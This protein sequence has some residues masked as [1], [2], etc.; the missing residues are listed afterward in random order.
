MKKYFTFLILILVL[1]ITRINRVNAESFYEDNYISG[2]YANLI[3]GDFSKPQQMRFIRRK[4]DN[5]PSYCITPRVLLYDTED[6]TRYYTF[7]QDVLNFS[8]SKLDKV[9]QI[10]YFGYGYPGHTEDYWYAITQVM[11]WKEIEPNMDIFF[12][13]TKNGNRILRFENEMNEINSLI[14]EWNEAPA[15]YGG[16]LTTNNEY[17]YTDRFNV[18]HNYE[19]VHDSNID[20]TIDNDI[21]KIKTYDTGMFRTMF[22]KNSNLY[23]DNPYVYTASKGQDIFVQGSIG[24]KSY[25]VFFNVTNNKLQITKQDSETLE[26]LKGAIYNLY[27]DKNEY[28][29]KLTTDSNGIG[30][31]EHLTTGNYKLK[32]E[33]APEGYLVD[34]NTYN[35]TINEELTTLNLKDNIIKANLIINKT[36]NNDND[37]KYEEGIKFNIYDLNDNLVTTL[38]TDNNGYASTNLKYGKYKVVQLNTTLGYKKVED[39]YVDIKDNKDIIYNLEDK[40][41]KSKLQV[42]KLDS[43]NYNLI[44]TASFKIKDLNKD[45]YLDNIYETNNGIFELDIKGGR[46]LLEEITPPINYIKGDNIEFTIDEELD[47]KTLSLNVFNIRKKGKIKIFKLGKLNNSSMLYLSNVIFDI[48]DINDNLVDTVTTDKLGIALSKELELGKYYIIERSTIDNFILDE[49]KYE[50][51]LVDNLEDDLII[52]D[53]I[54]TNNEKYDEEENIIDNYSNDSII[55]NYNTYEYKNYT[56]NYYQ[57][58]NTSYTNYNDYNYPKEQQA[59]L[60]NN[61]IDDEE[62]TNTKETIYPKTSD[63]DM[64]IYIII[65]YLAFIGLL[66]LI[67][68]IKD[69]K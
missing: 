66:Y 61:S 45:I 68:S 2:V 42:N 15:I 59:I 11:I 62:I 57:Y 25:T 17:E 23:A 8:E 14:N 51:D 35:I 6:Y 30:E 34:S 24:G 1:S 58:E 69:E 43:E 4:S 19:V 46:Y 44:D 60:L 36:L 9:N 31:I 53:I 33:K 64:Y 20:M 63:K 49:T 37:I 32:E 16:E 41:V 67:A 3:D 28:I 26:Y 39:F 54:I 55:N 22:R 50:I 18:L 10:A 29:G 47:N 48:Y 7:R 56:N 12:T 27:N 38:Q 40:I 65:G 5:K 21:L 52:K 13:D